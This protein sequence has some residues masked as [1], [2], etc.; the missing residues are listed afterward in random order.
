MVKT[1]SKSVI[2]EG[3]IFFEMI[4]FAV[5]LMLTGLLQMLYNMADSVVVGKFSG[6]NLALG[7]VGCTGSLTSLMTGVM[8]ALSAGASVVIA[9]FYGARNER[10]VSDAVHTSI[11]I[12]LIGGILLMGIGLIIARPLLSLMGTQELYFEKAELYV[13]I[14]C[15]GMPASALYNFGAATLRAVGDSKTSLYI[16][17]ISGFINVIL[18][19]VFV[20]C[21]DMSVEGVAAST[22]ISQYLSAAAVMAVLMRKRGECYGFSVKKLRIDAGVLKRVLY[23]GL[24]MM[25]Q[26]SLFSVSNMIFTSAVNS[27]PPEIIDAKA[28]AFN[29]EN[30]TYIV[31]NS[32]ANATV[33]YVG[34]NYGAGKYSRLNKIF[35]YSVIQVAAI[36]IF[37][38]FT[39]FIFGRSLSM[40]FIDA[41]NPMKDDILDGVMRIFNVML[42]TYFLC[43]IM[44]VLSTILK[45]LGFS[46]RSMVAVL[47]GMC[48]RVAWVLVIVPMPKFHTVEWLFSAYVWSWIATIIILLGCCLQA[49]RKLE[50]SKK[51]KLEKEEKIYE[52]AY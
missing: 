15:L 35:K 34:Q 48:I 9:Q 32:F 21:F 11:A 19:V 39:E 14:I 1:K 40:L 43:G 7:A 3:P 28:I 31:M 25:L 52:E 24:P 16:L 42:T 22:V 13:K 44:D 10:K 12:S 29:I 47:L 30:V 5:P 33:T 46:L 18:N 51:A 36:G 38:S 26:S 49:W 41:S 27:F 23:I 20:V 8:L 2:T 50:I 17:S 45:A 37:V 6:D 4:K